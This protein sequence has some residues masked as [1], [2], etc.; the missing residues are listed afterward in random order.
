MSY[1]DLYEEWLS[2]PYFDEDT[3]AQLRAIENDDKEI[4]RIEIRQDED[5]IDIENRIEALKKWLKTTA[6]TGN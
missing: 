2:N 6:E 5:K 3:K 1:R 4:E